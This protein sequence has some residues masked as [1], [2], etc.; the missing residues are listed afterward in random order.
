MIA[1]TTKL[2][3][4]THRMVQLTMTYG[5]TA[6]SPASFAN[7][8]LAILF[9]G[10]YEAGYRMGSLALRLSQKINAAESA[11][12]IMVVVKWFIGERIKFPVNPFVIST[13]SH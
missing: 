7:F 9:V 3:G 11:S 5:L 2:F 1:D 13:Y 10:N 6:F 12:N 8:G 4:V